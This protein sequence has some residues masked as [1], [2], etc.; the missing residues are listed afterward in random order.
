MN[1][2]EEPPLSPLDEEIETLLHRLA[3]LIETT[4]GRDEAAIR[5]VAIAALTDRIRELSRKCTDSTCR[6]RVF[7]EA[8]K[9][10]GEEE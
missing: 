10:L 8:R 2:F 9:M 5:E 6:I 4:P 1:T 3:A 7:R